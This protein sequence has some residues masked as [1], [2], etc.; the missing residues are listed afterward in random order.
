ME[1]DARRTLQLGTVTGG[2]AAGLTVELAV[3]VRTT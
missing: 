1:P 2:V 3:P